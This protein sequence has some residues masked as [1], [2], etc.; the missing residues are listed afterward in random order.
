MLEAEI[1]GHHDA[2]FGDA[3]IEHAVEEEGLQGGD[4]EAFEF[5][6]H[7][8]D[9]ALGVALALD[10]RRERPA[11]IAQ[12]AGPGVD[13]GFEVALGEELAGGEDHAVIDGFIGL[14]EE[15]I[16][17]ILVV[18]GEEGQAEHVVVAAHA[19]AHAGRRSWGRPV[20]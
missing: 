4:H 16:G 18:I 12:V 9:G 3:P 10:E 20:L 5:H 11:L 1:A 6:V 17:E 8:K 13:G 2:H 14:A 15:A 19:E 7:G